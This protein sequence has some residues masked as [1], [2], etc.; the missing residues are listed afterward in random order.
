M[1]A[2]LRSLATAVVF[3]CLFSLPQ[4]G[5]TQETHQ[6]PTALAMGG[7]LIIA[8]PTLLA[9]TVVGTAGFVVGLPFSALG[10]NV[11]ESFKT[12]MAGPGMATFVRCLGCR[13][14]RKPRMDNV[15]AAND[16]D[17]TGYENQQR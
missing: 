10:G 5:I 8:R 2:R 11:G 3:G 15:V 7:D 16:Y 6:R 14:G 9:L 1:K 17:Y 13:N 4:L 12:L